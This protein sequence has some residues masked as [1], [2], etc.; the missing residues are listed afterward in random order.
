MKQTRVGRQTL[1]GQTGSKYPEKIVQKQKIKTGTLK[2]G[3]PQ[4]VCRPRGQTKK[5]ENRAET[6]PIYT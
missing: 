4:I 5:I 6:E 1:I 3:Q 2:N